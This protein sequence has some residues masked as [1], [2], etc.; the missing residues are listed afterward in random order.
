MGAVVDVAVDPRLL[1]EG[2][3]H[4]QLG[5]QFSPLIGSPPLSVV[6]GVPVAL[7]AL[8][9]QLRV[10]RDRGDLKE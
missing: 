10:R 2:E 7:L 3:P 8:G 1:R 4:G 9:L 5:G 6:Y